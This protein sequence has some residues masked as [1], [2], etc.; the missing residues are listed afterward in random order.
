MP[1][2]EAGRWLECA[3]RTFVL[4]SSSTFSGLSE[5]R[6][7]A[8]DVAS[9]GAALVNYE[10]E[11][12]QLLRSVCT[13]HVLAV[14]TTASAGIVSVS[15]QWVGDD[16]LVSSKALYIPFQFQSSLKF[17]TTLIFEVFNNSQ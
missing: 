1:I 5:R 9:D 8:E 3:H 10:H 4:P 14:S 2:T 13:T 7:R 16:A 17:L 15:F 12:V 6:H 11:L